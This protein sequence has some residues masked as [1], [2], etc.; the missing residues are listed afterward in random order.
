VALSEHSGIAV[1]LRRWYSNPVAVTTSSSI[2]TAQ[3]KRLRRT[4][5]SEPFRVRE[6]GCPREVEKAGKDEES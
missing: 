4:V 6:E 5:S 1:R 2:R 3:R